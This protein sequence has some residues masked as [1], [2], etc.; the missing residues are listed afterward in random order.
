MPHGRETK[1]WVTT[2]TQLRCFYMQGGFL[3]CTSPFPVPVP[4]LKI[5]LFQQGA[6]PLWKFLEKIALVGCNSSFI[7]VMKK[8]EEQLKTFFITV[9]WSRNPSWYRTWPNI[10]SYLVDFPTQLTYTWIFIWKSAISYPF[11]DILVWEFQAVSNCA[12]LVKSHL[13]FESISS[14][15]PLVIIT[16]LPFPF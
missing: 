2:T 8:Q 15:L 14:W 5:L 13:F 9:R 6:F 4:K 10:L 16:S 11:S 3:K 1:D 12:E 7:L